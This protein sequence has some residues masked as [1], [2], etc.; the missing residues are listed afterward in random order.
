[1]GYPEDLRIPSLL[2]LA[3]EAPCMRCE[4]RDGTVVACHIQGPRA[5][6]AGKGMGKKPFDSYV[7]FLCY[8]CHQWMDQYKGEE[9]RLA[10]SEEFLWHIA[11]TYEWLWRNELITTKKG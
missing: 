11:R 3:K 2:S 8:E 6:R 10:H 7:A 4:V 1:M 5:Y 9:G